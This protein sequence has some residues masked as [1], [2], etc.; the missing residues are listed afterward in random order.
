MAEAKAR[1]TLKDVRASVSRMQNEGEKLV[2]R[3]RR[4][5]R[6]L[7]T[8]SRRE[9]VSTL[10][11]ETR[12]LQ[13]DFRQRAERAMKDLEARRTRIVASLE[14]QVQTLAE[15]VVKGLNVATPDEVNELRKRLAELERR[16]ERAA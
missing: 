12:K 16:I 1:L 10:L 7:A 14:E 3:I 9:A 4:D 5:A 2:A 13:S 15:R 11:S 6:S 8:R